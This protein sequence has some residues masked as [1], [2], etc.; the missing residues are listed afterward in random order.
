MFLECPAYSGAFLHHISPS[1][2]VHTKEPGTLK[3]LLSQPNSALHK[4]GVTHNGLDHHPNKNLFFSC[5]NYNLRY[6]VHDH[7]KQAYCGLCQNQTQ[8]NSCG[9]RWEQSQHISRCKLQQIGPT[10]L[11]FSITH[12]PRNINLTNKHKF[13]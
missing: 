2:K 4:L 12:S 1:S 5:F 10:Y 7:N 3:N 8:S 13:H 6:Q 9:V 11:N